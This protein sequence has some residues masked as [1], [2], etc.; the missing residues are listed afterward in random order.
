MEKRGDGM[1]ITVEVPDGTIALT[2]T[3]IYPDAEYPKMCMG[4][5]VL[6]TDDIQKQKEVTE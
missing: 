6:D 1:K 4:T 2:A 5:Q 3:Y